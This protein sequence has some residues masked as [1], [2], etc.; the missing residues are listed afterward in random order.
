MVDGRP[1]SVVCGLP[2]VNKETCSLLTAHSS[3]LPAHSAAPG[4]ADYRIC[5]ISSNP[6][7]GDGRGS[8]TAQSAVLGAADYK[9]HYSL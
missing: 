5:F 9:K 7:A 8:I 2:P 1:R 6:S 4:A 3:Q